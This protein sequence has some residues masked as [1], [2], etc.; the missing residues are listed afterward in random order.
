M[1]ITVF[2]DNLP[3]K[4]RGTAV[5]MPKE[6]VSENTSVVLTI[7]KY[8]WIITLGTV[9]LRPQG[10]NLP[11]KRGNTMN[12]KIVAILMAV[13]MAA[14]ALVVSIPGASDAEEG[15]L[16]DPYYIIGSPAL[17][18]TLYQS[19]DGLKA[20]MDFNEAAYT[21]DSI[22]FSYIYDGR[23]GSITVGTE[24]TVA[25]NSV[26]LL[27]TEVDTGIYE[28]QVK[29]NKEASANIIIK[30]SITTSYGGE[31]LTLDYY[32][33]VNVRGIATGHEDDGK[34]QIA[35]DPV[36][37]KSGEEYLEVFK[38][39]V[40][41]FAV[42][43]YD[44]QDS[45]KAPI[46]D[47]YNFY[48]SGL[49]AGLAVRVNT[50]IEL[51]CEFVITGKVIHSIK[52]DEGKDYASYP[53]VINAAD[54]NGNILTREVELRVF[55]SEVEF[56]FEVETEDGTE[57]YDEDVTKI[58]KAGSSISVIPLNTTGGLNTNV[59]VFYTGPDGDQVPMEVVD[60]KYTYESNEDDS[61]VIEII[62]KNTVGNVTVQHK[63]TAL[64]VGSIVHSGLDPVVTSS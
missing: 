8:H 46:K 54:A 3:T 38:G 30:V 18:A 50:D 49:P 4:Y 41:V 32:Y 48:A 42:W 53:V 9:I 40:P 64:I 1:L 16:D 35:V 28:V 22:K 33:G 13:I 5:W 56:E 34:Y 60:G 44:P 52:V 39:A 11:N 7:I 27:I 37:K 21:V 36:T 29:Y 57:T 14:A 58:I 61:G 2:I 20:R 10:R 26:K 19:G 6:D 31:E 25:S 15:T 62:M 43:V 47:T 12:S 45:T 24:K 59:D 55:P 51:D 17:P 63:V 23:T